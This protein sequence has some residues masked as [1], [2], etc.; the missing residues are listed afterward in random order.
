MQKKLCAV[1]KS[2]ASQVT[3]EVVAVN[4]REEWTQATKLLDEQ[5]IYKKVFFFLLNPNIY[6]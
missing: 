1:G 5:L 3:S 6:L 2:L 4:R